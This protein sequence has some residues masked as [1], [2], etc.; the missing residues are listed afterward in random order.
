VFLHRDQPVAM[1]PSLP[2][3]GLLL[4]A[5]HEDAAAFALA[6]GQEAARR[7]ILWGHDTGAIA[8]K[9]DSAGIDSATSGSPE[10]R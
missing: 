8:A 7:R 5:R 2:P 6:V 10:K 3:I 1:L 9:T 4:L